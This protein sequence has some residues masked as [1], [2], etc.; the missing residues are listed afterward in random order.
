M[1]RILF[2]HFFL[3]LCCGVY[4]QGGVSF[5]S[6]DAALQTAF[7]R[8][9]E[10]ALSYKGKATDPV[11][12]W[13]ESALPPRSAFCM[14]DVAHQSIGGEILGLS[15]ENKNMFRLFVNNISESKD[16]CSYWEINHLGKPAIEDYRN[17]TAFWYNL[18]ANFDILSASWK[19][20]LWTGD[21]EY[22]NGAGFKNFH[23]KSVSEYIKRWVLQAD[24]LLKRPTHPNAPVPFN[25]NDAFHRCRGLP[26]Y[27]EGV[28][29]IKMGVDLVGAIYSGLM[30]YAAILELKGQHD[31]AKQFKEKAVGYQKSIDA[32]W[33]NDRVSRYNTFYSNDNKFGMD[34]GETF[35]LWF[36]ALKA[37]ERKEKTIQHLL[38]KD[39][40]VE[41]LSYFPLIMYQNGQAEKAYGY[42]LHLTDPATARR[43]YPEVSFGVIKGFTEGL[44]GVEAD[45]RLNQIS[46]LYRGKKTTI[47]E[48]KDLPVLMTSITVKHDGNIATTLT[49]NGKKK[50]LWEPK[51]LDDKGKT[52]VKKAVWIKP[53]SSLKIKRA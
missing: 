8:A 34:E 9:K 11:G 24:S 53:G 14:R 40:N 26:S 44:M 20:Y 25:D 39:W 12:P 4:A 41:N 52:I 47:A 21:Q 45:A 15:K 10:M 5:K 2:V 50:I 19:L 17:D 35:L 46:T 33:W 29:N 6:T 43:E 49:N 32:L 30:S 42:L 36:D 7:V 16:W 48:L 27:S 31:K 1:K 51:F 37:G 22:I 13:Y 23:E 3:C 38:S 28:P 18:N